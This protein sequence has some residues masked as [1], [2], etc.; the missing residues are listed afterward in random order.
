M[1]M[2]PSILVNAMTAIMTGNG[3]SPT[4]AQTAEMNNFAN[5][6]IQMVQGATIAYDGLSL[7]STTSGNPIAEAA[8]TVSGLTIS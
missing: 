3:Q 6:I 7:L 4:D 1:A 2:D 5:A 8:P